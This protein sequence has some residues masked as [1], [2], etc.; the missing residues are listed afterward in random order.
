M[1][2]LDPIHIVA[3]DP[4]WP[5]LFE[6]QRARLELSLTPWATGPVEHIGST[7]VPGLPAKPIVDM[8]VLIADHDRGAEIAPALA[9]LG[10]LP[11][12]EPGDAAR[13]RW[14]F[15]YPSVERRTC[16]LHVLEAGEP[17]WEILLRFRDHLRRH[18]ADAAEYAAVK[19][20]LAAADHHDRPRY[21]AGKAPFI[22][23][24]LRAM[25]S[26]QDEEG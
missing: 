20:E 9:P 26:D 25:Q 8:A 7:A 19:R 17:S 3:Y 18:P 23:G 6:R 14:S 5:A 11:A 24:I 1:A 10:W 4:E 15:C 16:H 21:R 2:R 12:P 13:R 22:T